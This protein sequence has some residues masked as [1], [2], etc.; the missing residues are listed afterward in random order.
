MDVLLWLTFYSYVIKY[1]VCI[2]LDFSIFISQKFLVGI[3]LLMVSPMNSLLPVFIHNSS[4]K[5]I[6]DSRGG[7]STSTK[8]SKL[9]C[10]MYTNSHFIDLHIY[11]EKFVKWISKMVTT[12]K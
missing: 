2:Y 12:N 10:Y 8:A 7:F 6:Y 4:Y 3:K 5:H 11:I 1:A 9:Y